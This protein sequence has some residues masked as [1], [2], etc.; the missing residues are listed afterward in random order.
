MVLVFQ[1]TKIS[2]MTSS[3]SKD[4]EHEEEEEEDRSGAIPLGTVAYS[5]WA[6][7][8]TWTAIIQGAI[9]ALLIAML[10]AHC[11]HDTLDLSGFTFLKSNRTF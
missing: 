4:K 10:A 11:I 7:R 1:V 3:R 8:F 6:G 2:R 5:K 9:V